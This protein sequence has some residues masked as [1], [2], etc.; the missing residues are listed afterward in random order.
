MERVVDKLEEHKLEG[1]LA[2]EDCKMLEDRN[3]P[4]PDRWE[5]NRLG[6][7]MLGS[8]DWRERDATELCT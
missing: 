3:P 1:K 4:F 5:W 7:G 8:R 2:L 6:S